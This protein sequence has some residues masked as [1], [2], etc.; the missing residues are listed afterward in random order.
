[1]SVTAE[2]LRGQLFAR[3]SYDLWVAQDDE[4]DEIDDDEVTAARF[5]NKVRANWVSSKLSLV[6]MLVP[7]NQHQALP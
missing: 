1:M 7:L 4:D 2:S 6:P 3:G 5:T